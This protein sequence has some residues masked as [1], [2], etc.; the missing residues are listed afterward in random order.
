[1]QGNAD[2]PVNPCINPA[3]CAELGPVLPP[4]NNLV[5]Y[6]QM[7]KLVKD[8]QQAGSIFHPRLTS[9]GGLVILLGGV[10]RWM[11]LWLWN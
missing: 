9:W 7:A 2:N 6:R 1:M 8:E 4:D 3:A 11:W 5:F 10:L